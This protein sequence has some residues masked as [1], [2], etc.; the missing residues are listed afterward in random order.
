[1]K[2]NTDSFKVKEWKIVTT[3]NHKKAGVAMIIKENTEFKTGNITRYKNHIM[4]K[5]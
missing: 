1:M 4:P 3:H 2:K 5:W